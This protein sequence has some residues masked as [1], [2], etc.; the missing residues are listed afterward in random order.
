MYYHFQNT[1]IKFTFLLLLFYLCS[2]F[3]DSNMY[4]GTAVGWVQCLA[5]E[6]PHAA[7]KKKPEP[8]NKY[9][10]MNSNIHT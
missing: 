2:Y 4:T 6:L 9:I 1:T 10:H 7:K 8:T 3:T 5:Q